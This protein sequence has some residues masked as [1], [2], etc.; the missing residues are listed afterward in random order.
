MTTTNT[1]RFFVPGKIYSDS[2]GREYR[3]IRRS[4][5]TVTIEDIKLPGFQSRVAVKTCSTGREY[6][7]DD[8]RNM[9]A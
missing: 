5:K 2:A 6:V 4:E 7:G 1:P 3:I 9:Q 8:R